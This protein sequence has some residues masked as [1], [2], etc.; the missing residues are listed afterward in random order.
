MLQNTLPSLSEQEFCQVICRFLD[1]TCRSL[2]PIGNLIVN[3]STAIA[4]GCSVLQNSILAKAF[5]H[6]IDEFP[7]NHF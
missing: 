4:S 1:L 5:F 7:I 2:F 6:L 3:A